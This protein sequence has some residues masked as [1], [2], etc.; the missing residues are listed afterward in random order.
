MSEKEKPQDEAERILRKME[1]KREFERRDFDPAKYIKEIQDKTRLTERAA[2]FFGLPLKLKQAITISGF[3]G[4][5]HASY[6]D[7]M[8]EHDISIAAGETIVIQETTI[9]NDGNRRTFS[10]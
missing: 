10:R 8:I 9:H 1:E 2:H 6:E 3:E 7:M 4:H 5:G